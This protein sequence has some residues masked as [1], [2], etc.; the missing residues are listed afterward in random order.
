VAGVIFIYS[1][2]FLLT[3]VIQSPILPIEFEKKK[4]TPSPGA[5]KQVRYSEACAVHFCLNRLILTHS[6]L[7]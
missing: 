2:F 3:G 5:V 1:L 7:F 4:R 6:S